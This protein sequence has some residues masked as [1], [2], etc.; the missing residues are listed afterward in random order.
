[1]HDAYRLSLGV[2]FKQILHF[3]ATRCMQLRYKQLLGPFS[4]LRKA[5]TLVADLLTMRAELAPEASISICS[6]GTK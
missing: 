2:A 3:E 5:C 1:M 6:W 4:Y